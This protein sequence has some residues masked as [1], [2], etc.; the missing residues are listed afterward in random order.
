M[1]K[2]KDKYLL[3]IE[4]S[5]IYLFVTSSYDKKRRKYFGKKYGTD[6][7]LE[8]SLKDIVVE[9]LE[10][11]EASPTN[12]KYNYNNLWSNLISDINILNIEDFILKAI[13][14]YEIKC[15]ADLHMF[16]EGFNEDYTY[17]KIIDRNKIYLNSN[18]VVVK[19]KDSL[20][21]KKRKETLIKDFLKDILSDKEID[22]TKYASQIKD[23]ANY[24][25][26]NKKY[27]K[28]FIESLKDTLKIYDNEKLLEFLKSIELFP[29]DFQPIYY[30]LGLDHVYP[31]KDSSVNDLISIPYENNNKT[32]SAFTIDDSD[33]YDFDDGL[34]ILKDGEFYILYVHITDFSKIIS[35]DSIFSSYAKQLINTIYSPDK[36]FDLFSRKIVDKISL[37]EGEVRPAISIKFK[38][39]DFH[40]I[41]TEIEKN[42]IKVSN[43]F[44]Y[45]EF[46]SK[47]KKNPE[48]IFLNEFTKRLNLKRLNDAD[49]K[50]FNQEIGIKINKTNELVVK[51]LEPLES[52]R[53]ISELMIL[54]NY[55]FSEF[56]RDNGLPGIF[57][58]QKKSTNLETS[59]IG[60]EVPFCFHRK[61]SPVEIA[62]TIDFHH[63][64]GLDS[65][66]QITSPIRRYMDTINM[67][68]ISS[69]LSN[70]KILFD[71]RLIDKTISNLTPRLATMKEK[72]K[73]I[74]KFWILKYINQRKIHSLNGYIY[75]SLRDKYIIFFNELN[76]FESISKENCNNLYNKDDFIQVSFDF[77]DFQNLKLQNLKD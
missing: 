16:L 26:T 44:S 5:K 58:S 50:F 13:S 30:G 7:E 12:L 10:L 41:N 65:Y 40:I 55:K 39:K 33:T 43:N 37:K 17:Y 54:A 66:M 67:W 61:V 47:I 56:F 24:L 75:S 20:F 11:D 4:K 6:L 22:K 73:I 1:N 72:S 27:S 31:Y 59:I 15:L 60:D 53:I 35:E 28:N 18:G 32:L 36:N 45:E 76:L 25:S 21:E 64:L 23:I 52:R 38:L 14:F 70:G 77:I 29:E 3:I 51:Y 69:F 2:M 57:R 48:F 63:G 19:I 74:Y 49:F 62:S 68:Q 46:E 34:T 8:I 71:K 9:N 42:F